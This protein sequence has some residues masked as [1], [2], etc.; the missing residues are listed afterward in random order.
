M[1][2]FL[3]VETFVFSEKLTCPRYNYWIVIYQSSYMIV[4]DPWSFLF[5][6][7]VA[8]VIIM[9]VAS[10]AT[11]GFFV[12]DDEIDV[13]GFITWCKFKYGLE[14]FNGVIKRLYFERRVSN[15]SDISVQLVIPCCCILLEWSLVFIEWQFSTSST[16]SPDTMDL[17]VYG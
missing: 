7:F 15:N 3:W 17:V 10:V 6:R 13:V 11:K 16:P 5:S 12:V 14:P 1:S 2:L 9:L 8:V 4:I